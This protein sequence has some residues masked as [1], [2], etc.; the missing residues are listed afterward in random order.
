MTFFAP[1]ADWSPNGFP[2]RA[3][4]G[5][6]QSVLSS[7]A[8]A[9]QSTRCVS[10]ACRTTICKRFDTDIDLNATHGSDAPA[11]FE[12]SYYFRGYVLR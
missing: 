12:P 9:S 2:L 7:A 4:A 8:S 5:M 1:L 10:G 11:S 6:C 3:G